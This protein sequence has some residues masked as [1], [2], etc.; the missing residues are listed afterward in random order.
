MTC[1]DKRSLRYVQ[2]LNQALRSCPQGSHSRQAVMPLTLTIT[3]TLTLTLTQASLQHNHPGR[4]LNDGA[5]V[6]EGS[7]LSIRQFR[8]DDKYVK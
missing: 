3:L 1:R 2:A 4:V 7:L 5:C 6:L 8:I